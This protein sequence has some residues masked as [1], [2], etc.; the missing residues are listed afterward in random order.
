[1]SA[2][3]MG[4][5]LDSSSS[6][7]SAR[8]VLLSIC[9]HVDPDGEGWAYVSTICREARVSRD[10][11]H[12]AAKALE[13]AGELERISNGGGS[14]RTRPDARPNLFQLPLFRSSRGMQKIGR[15]SCRARV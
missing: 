12:R 15:A 10:T 6:T 9:N 3:A 2:Q 8:L 4:W 14:H 7:G 1:M 5:A 13:E 11:Y